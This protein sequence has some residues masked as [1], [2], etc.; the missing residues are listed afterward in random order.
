MCQLSLVT[1]I[2]EFVDYYEYFF[3]DRID[4]LGCQPTKKSQ[5]PWRSIAAKEI[6][7]F[8]GGHGQPR[9]QEFL[10]GP[11]NFI[12]GYWQS[13]KL[14]SLEVVSPQENFFP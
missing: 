9:K 2:L 3:V 1:R 4:F 11:N 5:L 13:R 8:L 7:S 12:G 10:G 14:L 6:Y